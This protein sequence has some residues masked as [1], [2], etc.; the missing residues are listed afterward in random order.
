VFPHILRPTFPYLPSD[1]EAIRSSRIV[2]D[3]QFYK[4][5]NN[6]E[7]LREHERRSAEERH[8]VMQYVQSDEDKKREMEELHRKSVLSE[9]EMIR[10]MREQT[11]G[12]QAR[13]GSVG[14]MS[15]AGLQNQTVERD[16]LFSAGNNVVDYDR[17]NLNVIWSSWDAG[18]GGVDGLFGFDDDPFD[19]PTW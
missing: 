12:N 3:F 4:S 13:V 11:G 8:V 9:D 6:N 2:R 7:F 15:G 18:A 17:R 5:Q 1:I 16:P 10:L 14:D 19:G